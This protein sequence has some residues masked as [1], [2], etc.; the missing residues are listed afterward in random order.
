MN[1]KSILWI[2]DNS[3]VADGSRVFCRPDLDPVGDELIF[4]FL[5]LKL[6]WLKG[7]LTVGSVEGV[8]LFWTERLYGV[9][10]WDPSLVGVLLGSTVAMVLS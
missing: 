5:T 6:G 10:V 7:V 1:M 4:V 9:D 2:S 8:T 3:F